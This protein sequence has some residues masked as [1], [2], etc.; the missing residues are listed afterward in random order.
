M[1][2]LIKN[3]NGFFPSVP[4]LFDDFFTRDLF[5]HK[6]SLSK[7]AD[8]LPAVNIQET[9]SSFELEVAAPGMNKD[10]FNIELNNGTLIINAQRT[11]EIE[12]KGD[13][14]TRKEFNYQQFQRSFQ[15]PQM[16]IKEEGVSAQYNDGILS[17][18]IPKKEN[19]EVTATRKITIS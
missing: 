5:N 11:K 9:A 7:D 1:G 2:T 16:A 17:I 15:L 14:Y 6:T 13:N 4:S 12:D 3:N 19:S 18:S 10:D 8:T